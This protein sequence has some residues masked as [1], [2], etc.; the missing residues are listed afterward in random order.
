MTDRRPIADGRRNRFRIAAV[1]GLLVGVTIL[2]DCQPPRRKPTAVER[3]PSIR[4]VW[5]TRWDFKTA[6]DV[7][8]IMDNCR[9][10]GFNTVLFQV[11]G[12]GTAFYRSRIE[13]WAEELGGRDPGFDPL[14]VACTEAHRRGMQLHAWANVMPAWRGKNPPNNAKQLY[15]THPEWFWRDG[16][17]RRQPLGWYQSINPCYP[18]VRR[19][20]VAVMNEIVSG[21]PIDGLHLDYI[22]FPNEWNASYPRGHR[23]PDYPRDPRTLSMFREA[24]GATPEGAPRRWSAWRSEQVTALVRDL[25][26]MVKR[27]KPKVVL[28]AA[29]GADAAEAK[30]RHFQ[31]SRQWI[32]EGL[33]DAV[34]PM[35]YAE[36]DELFSRRLRAWTAAGPKVPVVTGIMFDQRSPDLVNRQVAESLRRGGH[37]AAFAYNSMFERYDGAGRPVGGE[38]SPNRVALRRRVIPHI[39]RLASKPLARGQ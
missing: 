14:A 6:E 16:Q 4:A 31:D 20:L 24:T 36:D 17:G 32:E 34:Y 5:V 9:R 8:R 22:R 11:R 23:V 19:Y 39:Q 15:H 33:L 29:V 27:T 13:P 18:E 38:D 10:A 12:N 25:R 37:F 35:N 7:R 30:R 28:S 1:L 2:V 21:Y 3:D 26:R